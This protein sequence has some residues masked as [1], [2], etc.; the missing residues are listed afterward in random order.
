MSPQLDRAFSDLGEPDKEDNRAAARRMNKVL[1]VAGLT[2]S[3]D[4]TKQATDLPTNLEPMAEA[5][6]NG[7][8]AQRARSGWSWAAVRDDNAKHHPSML[9]Y[10]ELSEQEKEKDRSNIRHYPEFATGAGCRIV[11]IT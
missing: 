5:E 4:P 8:M 3:D 6:H 9:P 7:W 11:R 1:A 10:G 2:L